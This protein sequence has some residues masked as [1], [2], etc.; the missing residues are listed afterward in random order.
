[1]KAKIW[2]AIIILTAL[3][4]SASYA[5]EEIANGSTDVSLVFM[6]YGAY[7]GDPCQ[8]A[9]TTDWN[10]KYYIDGAAAK[11]SA[12]ATVGALNSHT[13]NSVKQIG[14]GL[15]QV[16]FP[17]TCFDG[18]VGTKVT[19][20]L[21]EDTNDII[22]PPITV[23]LI[24]VQTGDSY[25]RLGAPAGASV[26]ADIA[27]IEAQTD[28]IGAAGAGLTEAGGTGDH[29]TAIDLPNQTMDITGSLS[30]SVG[31]VTVSGSSNVSTV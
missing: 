11:V 30:G 8:T 17:D 10:L 18:G 1:M 31:S 9:S 7:S 12:N 22:C 26:S 23:R 3:L 13:D 15:Y 29:L 27:A 4:G 25:T 28:D 16:D 6:V 24:A 5:E 14:D 20:W 19:C 2:V 21:T